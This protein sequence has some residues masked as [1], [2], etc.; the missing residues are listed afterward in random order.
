MRERGLDSV[1]TKVGIQMCTKL[2]GAPWSVVIPLK[3]VMTIGFDI[4][5]DS[6]NKNISY[7][8]LVAT[9]DLQVGAD[10]YSTVSRYEDA[11]TMSVEFS[12]N[13]VKAL[14]VYQEK[15][16]ALPAHIFIYRGGVGDGQVRH[17]KETEVENLK[18]R[19]K[20][21][22]KDAPLKLIFIIVSK[23]INTRLFRDQSNPEAGTVVDQ[24]I[25]LPER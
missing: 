5:K 23:R 14:R 8:A 7:G 6:Q 20:D 19:L 12:L 10:F 22:Y 18:A 2:G 17:I 4:S 11:E 1:I 25:T 21:F 16:Q 3:G 24:V 15:H 9:M 13:V